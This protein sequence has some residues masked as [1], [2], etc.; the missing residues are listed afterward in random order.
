MLR[1]VTNKKTKEKYSMAKEEK[2]YE[3][4]ATAEQTIKD[5]CEKYPDVLWRVKPT[6]IAVLTVISWKRALPRPS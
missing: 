6:S 4:V 1:V 3:R 5:L 2:I